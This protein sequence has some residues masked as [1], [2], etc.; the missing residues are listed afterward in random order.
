MLPTASV[1]VELPVPG[2]G[3]GFGL[4][5]TVVWRGAPEEDSVIEE[6]NPPL[7]VVCTVA[8]PWFPGAT[9]I[10]VGVTEIEKL[11][12]AN[13]ACAKNSNVKRHR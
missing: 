3:I 7:P 2:D 11:R 4:K 8:C 12:V 9:V 1:T 13:A 6:L 10:C 5:L